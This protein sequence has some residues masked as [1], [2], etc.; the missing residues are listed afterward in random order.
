[1][2][3]K[4]F[5]VYLFIYLLE[6]EAICGGCGKKGHYSRECPDRECHYCHKKGH[7]ARICPDRKNN[8]KG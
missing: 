2:I 6:E 8:R 7:I 1:M 5:Q 3:I 4:V